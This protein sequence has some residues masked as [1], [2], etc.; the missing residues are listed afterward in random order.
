[1]ESA[2][3][4]K[5]EMTPRAKSKRNQEYDKKKNRDK[6]VERIARAAVDIVIRNGRDVQHE[7]RLIYPHLCV[8]IA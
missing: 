5:E 4:R 8:L 2:E 3:W 7:I 1:V 6:R